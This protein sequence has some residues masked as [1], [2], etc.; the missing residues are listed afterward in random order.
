M[1]PTQQ[2]A[3]DGLVE[4][5]L[6]NKVKALGGVGAT[7]KVPKGTAQNMI[8][9]G[10]A[11]LY[12]DAQ[13]KADAAAEEADKL[14]KAAKDKEKA[15][16]KESAAKAKAAEAAAKRAAARSGVDVEPDAGGADTGASVSTS[17]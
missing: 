8:A 1:P 17:P 12:D 10:V 11:V 15:A 13:K 9:R 5:K 6:R 4:V 16:A 3:T 7:V 14:A 2:A